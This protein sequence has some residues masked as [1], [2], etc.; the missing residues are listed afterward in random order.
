LSVD[1]S[2]KDGGYLPGDRDFKSLY[3]P[4]GMDVFTASN[5]TTYALMANE[6]D[7]RVRP[8]DVNF[9]A[10][11]DGT[12]TL[13]KSKKKGAV[14]EI[15]DPLTGKTVYVH[16]DMRGQNS[17]A[18]EAE[19]GD[20]FF[21]TWK[22]GAV[23]DDDFYSDEKRAG[24]LDGPQGNSIVSGDGEGRLKTVVDQNT[25]DSITGFGGRSFTIR[26]L[27][28]SI[29]WDSGDDLDRIAAENDVYD[30]G[31][32]D[33]KGVEP[34]HV[35]IATLDDRSFAFI[36]LERGTSTLI[37]VYEITNVD[38][39]EHVYTFHAANSVSPEATEF[40][41]TSANGGTLLVSSEVS[42]TLDAFNFSTT[43]V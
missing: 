36:S 22:H 23:A 8:D 21:I 33:D 9:E 34:E 40:V 6:G 12:F 35:E 19:A 32:S 37:P 29:V 1:T 17:T 38:A 16:R 24:K 41:K 2:D 7:G 3:M 39:P 11:A 25:A 26:G 30:D 5:G 43:L 4:D 28:G 31:R 20:E 14:A 42:G 13:H 27:D 15:E 10:D 18:F